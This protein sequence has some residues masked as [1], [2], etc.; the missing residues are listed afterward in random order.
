MKK[1]FS[2]K[3]KAHIALE[4]IKNQKSMSELASEYEAHPIQIGVWKKMLTANA[5]HVFTDK[6]K[7]EHKDTQDLIDRLYRIIGQRDIELEW[8]KKKL[9]LES[10]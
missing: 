9:H 7:N 10:S 5:E 6:R 3:Q 2:P 8:L 1:A 4:A